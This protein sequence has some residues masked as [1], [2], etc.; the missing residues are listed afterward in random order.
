MLKQTGPVAKRSGH[1]SRHMVACYYDTHK[2][3]RKL[4]RA[5]TNQDEF[6]LLRNLHSVNKIN[7]LCS[8]L[9]KLFFGG[10]KS[11]I[12]KHFKQRAHPKKLQLLMGDE[13]RTPRVFARRKK[14]RE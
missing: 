7:T 6:L 5:H 3:T 14:C 4:E 1:V 13:E 9:P 2:G 10:A 11:M 12:E 8:N